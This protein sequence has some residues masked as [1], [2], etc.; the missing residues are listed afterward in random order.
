MTLPV[1]GLKWRGTTKKAASMLRTE[2]M[3]AAQKQAAKQKFLRLVMIAPFFEFHAG[4]RLCFSVEY[5][6]ICV[7]ICSSG[8]L[9]CAG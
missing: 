9:P 2:T 6:N 1:F 4:S 7:R 8:G 3:E 5:G